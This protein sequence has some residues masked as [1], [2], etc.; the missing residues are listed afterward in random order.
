[1][2]HEEDEL[3]MKSND[4]WQ[5]WYGMLSDDNDEMV[6]NQWEM[7]E[8]DTKGKRMRERDYV[9]WEIQQNVS[10]FELYK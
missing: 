10:L 6:M 2:K 9:V 3:Q 5:M 8:G 4:R 7:T 1:M